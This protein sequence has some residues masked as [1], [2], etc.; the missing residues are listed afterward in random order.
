MAFPTNDTL[1]SLI[2]EV[3]D[4]LGSFGV[5]NDA[6][7]TLT[8]PLSAS[9]T[10]FS[11]DSVDDIGKGIVEIDG[12]IMYV[13]SAENGTVLLA[14][15][16]RGYK[17]TAKTTHAAN[18]PVWISPTWPRATVAREINN[19]VK[20]LYPQLFAVGSYDF[21]AS[22]SV[23]NQYAMPTDLERVLS[24][25]WRWGGYKQWEPVRAWEMS[26][27]SAVSDFASGKSLIIGDPIPASTQVH[28]TYAKQPTAM[29]NESDSF[30]TTGLPTSCRDV[31]VL[32][33]AQRL[34]PWQDT[35]RIPVQTVPSDM[36]DSIKPVGNAQTNAQYIRA[37]Y[38]AR[39]EEEIRHQQGKFPMRAHK[40]R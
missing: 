6:V 31:V 39:L 18:S 40:V 36:V 15:W 38:T 24:V 33:V 5:T 2:E 27:S 37:L 16:G 4:N 34:I 7:C 17:G 20:A 21:D 10:S 8:S 26:H 35:A 19:M 13:N 22:M 14:P 29:V 12:E 9:A 25:E 1:G 23:T 30:S 3:K 32:G 11:V 28:V